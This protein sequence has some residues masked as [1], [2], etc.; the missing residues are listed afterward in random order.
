MLWLCIEIYLTFNMPAEHSV[1]KQF[2]QLN[3]RLGIKPAGLSLKLNSAKYTRYQVGCA[4]TAADSS[5]SLK[6]ECAMCI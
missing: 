3:L 6:H 2:A 1:H 5:G 4:T